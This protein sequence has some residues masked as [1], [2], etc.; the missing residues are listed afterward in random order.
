MGEAVLLAEATRGPF[1]ESRHLGHA[2]IAAADGSL[3]E[4]WGN[5]DERVYARSAA[6][7]LQALPLVES[8]A[9]EGLTTEQL[10]L[11]CASHSAE[12]RHV[13]RVR[14]WLNDLGL[15][16]H[17][18]CCGPQASRDAALAEDMIRK[19]TPVTRAFNWCSGKHSGF[20]TLA[21]HL[22][23]SL[24]YVD[25]DN[26]VQKAVRGA[27][28]DITGED[29]PGFGFDGCSA[30][31][32]ACSLGGMARAMAAIAGADGRA[33][34]RGRAA[35]RLR[36]AMLAH[37]EMVAGQG[38]LDTELVKHATEPVVLKSGAEGFYIAILPARRQGIALKI[39]DGGDR[40]AMVAITALLVRLGVLDAENPGV[41]AFLRPVLK[42]WAGLD[43][44]ELRPA[45]ALL[46]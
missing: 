7:I 26:P 10:A 9:A 8:G 45:S 5:P 42:N 43:V 18:L 31:N 24:D 2:V 40:G 20:L 19:G 27:F 1:V 11:A 23:A 38:R 22:G 34:A 16:E 15:D 29:S 17:A 25:I 4:A 3:V 28:E 6:K 37:P 30:P 39:A 14:R 13:D 46:P 41:R 12:M 32:F 33:D 35:V 44:G 36:D 21:R